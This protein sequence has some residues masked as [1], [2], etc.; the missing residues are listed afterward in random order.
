MNR[1]VGVLQTPAL[2]LGYV[3]IIIRTNLAVRFCIFLLAVFLRILLAVVW[4]MEIRFQALP[5]PLNLAIPILIILILSIIILKTLTNLYRIP[6]I[7]LQ[8]QTIKTT[9]LPALAG[10]SALAP[11][12]LL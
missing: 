10:Q 12:A 2:P 1:R 8:I 9:A 7:F 11:A 5:E 3:A 4:E 6:I